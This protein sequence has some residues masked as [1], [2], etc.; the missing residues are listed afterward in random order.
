MV[1]SPASSS[2]SKA[3]DSAGCTPVVKCT[4]ETINYQHIDISSVT[5]LHAAPRHLE[6]GID[7]ES[8]SVL[9]MVSFSE[10]SSQSQE[11][12]N[13]QKSL[14]GESQKSSSPAVIEWKFFK[15]KKSLPQASDVQKRIFASSPQ[16][17]SAKASYN[18]RSWNSEHNEETEEKTA[19][20]RKK[21]K[22]DDAD[23][24]IIQKPEEGPKLKREMHWPVGEHDE[25]YTTLT[26]SKSHK[27][28]Y[29]VIQNV[30]QT[31][32]V[33]ELGET[34]DFIKEIDYLLDSLKETNSNTIRCLSCLQLASKCISPAFRMHMR[35][36]GTISR[37][38]NLL[39]D[40]CSDPN[41]ALSTAAL[42]FVLSR[43]RLSMDLDHHSLS[44]MLK[45]N[46]NDAGDVTALGVTS[47]QGLERTRQKVMELL[48]LLQETYSRE[49][50]LDFVSTSSLAL[51]SLLS[52]TSRR[53]GEGFKEE[54]RSIGGLDHIVDSVR[55]CEKNLPE[56]LSGNIQKS[57]SVLRKLIRC[58]RVLENISYM[59]SENQNY[60]LSYRNSVLLQ[61][62]SRILRLC[63]LCLPAFKLPENLDSKAVK[64]LP[65]HSVLSCML[66]VLR[67]MINI[68]HSTVLVQLSGPA[69]L[70]VGPL[71]ETVVICLT[72]TISCVP[73]EQRFDLAVQCLVLLT[74]LVEHHEGNRQM[75]MEMRIPVSQ[76]QRSL[77]RT[78]IMSAVSAVVKL[79]VQ[80]EQAA[81]EMEEEI[82]GISD[83]PASPSF[84]L[85]GKQKDAASNV[86]QASGKQNKVK[87]K[88][89]LPKT[90]TCSIPTEES[91]GEHQENQS[92][93]EDCEETFTK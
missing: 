21:K 30:R 85:T 18:M 62:C 77:A 4:I 49:V 15:S 2:S 50:D 22:A 5:E 48:G 76:A 11:T 12:S 19:T 29:T 71:M 81:R 87:K 32:E 51:E 86:R 55:F 73:V 60:L 93:L 31:H 17:L 88:Q 44:L 74:N 72:A 84:S 46:E 14:E 39:E 54:L 66:I 10:P 58:L 26:V 35:V 45:L 92:I 91:V 41:L 56:D 90:S 53:A 36:H 42:M 1:T 43:D 16:K 37:I 69:S 3:S 27:E 75:F 13:S 67:V 89:N 78:R 7:S 40:A 6:Q 80:R 64:D 8:V 20:V 38:F 61:S 59:N 23:V 82:G 70:E 34:H 52:L 9:D 65:G 57:L 83:S 33:Q 25:A 47:L 68:T 28:L 63:Q 24:V 79:F